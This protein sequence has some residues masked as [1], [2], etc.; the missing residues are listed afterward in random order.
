MNKDTYKT[1][2]QSK[3]GTPGIVV[4]YAHWCGACKNFLPV[5]ESL[6]AKQDK[7][8]QYWVAKLDIGNDA[9]SSYFEIVIRAVPTVILFNRKGFPKILQLSGSTPD[10]RS[11]YVLDQL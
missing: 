6:L 11:Q 9:N 1:F 8:N 10:E 2:I 4:F 3:K 5:F 7:T